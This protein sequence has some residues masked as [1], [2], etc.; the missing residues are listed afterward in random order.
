MKIFLSYGHDSNAPLIEKIKEYL[1]KDVKGNLKHEVWIDTSEIKEGKDWREKITKGVLESDVVLAGLSKHSTQESSVCRNELNISIG[2]KG[3]NIKTI[4]LEPSDV[5]APPAMISHIQ[6]LDMS[7]WKEREKEGF[8]SEYFQEKFRQIAEMIETPEN[9][10]F[11]GE[12]TQLKETLEPISSLSRLKSL[13]Q[14]E[15]YGRIW[16][17]EK[18]EE[19]DKSSNHRLFWIV[20]GPGFGKS[21][22]AA[23]LQERYNARIPAIQFVEWG[24]PDHSS[25]CRILKNLAFQLA[26]RYPE[27]RT[28]VLQQSDVINNKLNEKNEDELFELLFCESTWMKIDGGQENVWVLIDALDE[29][30]DEYGNKIA[31]T[32]AR[33]MDRMPHWMRF[34][35][36]SRD[37]SKVRLPLQ[38]YHP[39][40]FDLEEYVKEKNSEDLLLYVRCELDS[41]HPTEEQVQQIVDKS[42]GV[43]LYLSLCVEGINNGEYSL[44]HID[45]L[46]DGLNGY[47]YELFTRQFGNDIEKY[48]KEIAPIL[49][50][51]VAAK[52][53]LQLPFIKYLLDI[54]DSKLYEVC[55]SL[56]HICNILDENGDEVISFFHNSIENWITNHRQSGLF[57]VSKEEG[58]IIIASKYVEWLLNSSSNKDLFWQNYN[59]GLY[60]LQESGYEWPKRIE[61]AETSSMLSLMHNNGGLGT[62]TKG[63]NDA[64]YN[65]CKQFLDANTDEGFFGFLGLVID[66]FEK[67]IDGYVES[68]IVSKKTRCYASNYSRPIQPSGTIYKAISDSGSIGALFRMLLDYPLGDMQL[69]LAIIALDILAFYDYILGVDVKFSSVSDA[70][71]FTSRELLGISDT[72]KEKINTHKDKAIPAVLFF[73]FRAIRYPELYSSNGIYHLKELGYIYECLQKKEDAISL[74]RLF[75]NEYSPKGNGIESI[76][77]IANAYE[78]IA[79]LLSSSNNDAEKQQSVDALSKAEELYEIVCRESSKY[80]GSLS[81]IQ[82]N[83]GL[84]YEAIGNRSGAIQILKKAITN[85]LKIEDKTEDDV[86]ALATYYVNLGIILSNVKDSRYV[87]KDDLDYAYKMFEECEKYRMQLAKESPTKYLQPLGFILL[88]MAGFSCQESDEYKTKLY[89]KKAKFVYERTN[90][91]RE[92]YEGALQQISD[93]LSQVKKTCKSFWGLFRINENKLNEEFEEFVNYFK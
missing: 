42:Q 24:K 9:E 6:W 10:R 23:N 33:H 71:D 83:L 12:I 91:K 3:G 84:E 90:L 20:A 74:Y 39:Q 41:L 5:V 40:I 65:Q 50:L 66:L 59:Y 78:S 76:V 88:R 15:M 81:A 67:V 53:N 8:E 82:N 31:Q 29:A 51:M 4:L 45:N 68:G 86:A 57:Y 62:M 11:N 32:L 47:Y 64:I 92:Q 16:L 75:V 18:I 87:N 22:F 27:Y 44:D 37:D 60:H 52:K 19:W 72:L 13:T 35:L 61:N 21:M 14:K 79:R 56:E 36:T 48:K 77:A 26:V 58:H 80:Y 89:L 43:F 85:C 69:S 28:F 2:V 55:A 54:T 93:H 30:N 70:G 17:Y 1:S 7:D 25:P 63:Q 46:P 73:S 38:K 34:I 49:Q